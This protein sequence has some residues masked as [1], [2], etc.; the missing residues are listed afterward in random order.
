MGIPSPVS[1]AKKVICV[2]GGLGVAPIFPQARAFKGR[3][4][5]T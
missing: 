1:G 4:V 2:G 5:P 3:M